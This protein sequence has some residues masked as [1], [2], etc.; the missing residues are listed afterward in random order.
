MHEKISNT[1]T[2]VIIICII[3]W[4]FLINIAITDERH[5]TCNS[6]WWLKMVGIFQIIMYIIWFI[7][8]NLALYN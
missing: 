4:G 6:V 5:K 7:N 1:I 8:A 3:F 2:L